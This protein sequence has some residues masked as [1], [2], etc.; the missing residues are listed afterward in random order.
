VLIAELPELGTL[1][2]KR[3]AAL[4]GVAPVARDRGR[5]RGKRH[6]AGGR[7]GVRG[8]LDMACL[9][10]VRFNPALRAFYRRLRQAGKAGQ[11]A[12]VAA[13]R[14]LL[15]TLN[16]MVRDHRPWPPATV[17]RTHKIT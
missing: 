11:V 17:A 6:I 1:T 7:T 2:G 13:M 12:L 8:A 16:A 10:A 9:S 5:Q 4:V 3:I 14:K 15:V